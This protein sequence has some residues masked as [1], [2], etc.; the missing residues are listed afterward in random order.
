[1]TIGA[2]LLAALA[3]TGCGASVPTAPVTP[4]PN[5][6]LPHASN[7]S[8][9]PTTALRF[10]DGLLALA[11]QDATQTRDEAS[12]RAAAAHF[13]TAADS[14]ESASIRARAHYNAGVAYQRCKLDR[15]AREQ[16]AKALA[17]EP[18]FHR[19][20]AELALLDFAASGGKNFDAAIAELTR[21]AVVDAQFKDATSLVH[22]GVLHLKR[23]RETPD[24]D[25]LTDAQRAKKY[26]QSALAVDDRALPAYNLLALIHLGTA[27]RKAEASRTRGSLDKKKL[28]TQVLE[29]A[30]LVCS[31]A[32]RKDPRYAP[33]HN[34]AGMIQVELGDFTAA[35]RSFDEAR[36][37]D[38]SFFEAHMNFAA[39]NLRFRGFSPAE[40]AYRAALALRPDDYD[41]RIGLAHALRGQIDDGNMTQKVA[42][43]QRELAKAK[44]SAPERP[45]A[46]YNEGILTQEYAEIAGSE[47]PGLASRKAKELFGV[48]LQK[49]GTDPTYA[50]AARRARERIEEIEQIEGFM[51]HDRS[52]TAAERKAEEAERKNRMAE[53]EARAG[54]E[55]APKPATN[56]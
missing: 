20:R 29:L 4:E 31:Q 30:A 3:L 22:L 38:P 16:F 37:I 8:A 25:G 6:L 48:F 32:I 41:A 52:M 19:A 5:P 54:E 43:V 33:I 34:T 55:E 56:P 40:R 44:Q 26:A 49:A 42:E 24:A 9:S 12:C 35:A 21:A 2:A 36:R 46:Y 23:G 17:A 15:E 51:G 53:E 27:Q 7:E 18:T 14:R 11:R 28:D 10:R 45:E 1:M 50:D 47:Q 39:V 13:T